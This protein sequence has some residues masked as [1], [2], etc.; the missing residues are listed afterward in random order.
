M[1]NG[2]GLANGNRGYPQELAMLELELSGKPFT[3]NT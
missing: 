1:E 2:I 3:Q